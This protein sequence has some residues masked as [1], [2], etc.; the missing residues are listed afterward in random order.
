MRQ[1]GHRKIFC[2]FSFF[3]LLACQ[4][5]LPVYPL[6]LDNSFVLS[7]HEGQIFRKKDLYDKITLLYFGFTRCPTIC[8]QNLQRIQKAQELIGLKKK[9]LQTL[10]LSVDPE[11]DKPAVLKQYL[12]AYKMNVLGLWAEAEQLKR[13]SKNFGLASHFAKQR[14]K[15][16]G[17]RHSSIE[18][19]SY[20]FLLD[21]KAR[22]RYLFRMDA[23]VQKIAS[24]IRRL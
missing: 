12:S 20:I 8:P 16:S 2:F 23:S 10:M 1:K 5:E 11:Y 21:K 22:F 19:S 3:L 7:T 4:A 15:K 18:H 6:K 13:I 17:E 9:Q 24:I 14:G